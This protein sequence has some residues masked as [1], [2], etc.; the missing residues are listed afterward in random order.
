MAS[1]LLASLRGRFGPNSV[2][3]DREDIPAGE[4]WKD[5]LRREISTCS[6]FLAL[7]GDEWLKASNQDSG[8]RR[9]DEK[10]DPVRVEI[11]VA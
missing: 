10:N 8:Q 11:E 2:F 5:V 9:L 6:V 3:L 7:I 4:N 1:R